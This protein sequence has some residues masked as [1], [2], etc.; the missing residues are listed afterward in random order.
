DIGYTPLEDCLASVVATAPLRPPNGSERAETQWRMSVDPLRRP[1]EPLEAEELEETI[2]RHAFAT[3][4]DCKIKRNRRFVVNGYLGAKRK[5]SPVSVR[6]PWRGP[7]RTQEATPEQI[8]CLTQALEQWSGWPKKR[9]YS[10]VSFELRWMAAP[11]S[12]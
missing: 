11:P 1:A 7:S 2:K 4:E 8:A 6:V 12:K 9:G 10:K 5:L 3:Y